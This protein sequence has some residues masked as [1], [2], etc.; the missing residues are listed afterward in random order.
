MHL[1]HKLRKLKAYPCFVL[2][3]ILLDR[4]S[5]GFVQIRRFNLLEYSGAPEVLKTRGPGQVRE[6]GPPDISGM[7][8]L[9]IPGKREIFRDRFSAGDRCAVAVHEGKIVGYEWYTC[10]AS[11]QEQ[12]YRYTITVPA[13]AIYAYD[14]FI[15]PVYRISGL[16]IKLKKHLGGQ[17]KLLGRRRIIT[18]IDG[19]NTLSLNTHLRFGFRM[20]KSVY[21]FKLAGKRYFHESSAEDD[22]AH[23][24]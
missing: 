18:L 20:F 3:Q 13:E 21:F 12:R 24:N 2:L 5:F 10:K 17:M 6:G 8:T 22:T 7:A 15:D 4:I 23:G 16:W 1:V 19:E 9:G 14:A 11:H